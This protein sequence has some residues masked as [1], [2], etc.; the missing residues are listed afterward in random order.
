[1][2][3]VKFQ[4]LRLLNEEI[5]RLESIR[6][7]IYAGR[8]YEKQKEYEENLNCCKNVLAILC[9]DFDKLAEE[10]FL[11]DKEKALAKGYYRDG[12]DW[13]TAFGA[14]LPLLTT[15]KLDLY[16]KNVEK[17]EL[18]MMRLKKSMIRKIQKYFNYYNKGE[19]KKSNAGKIVSSQDNR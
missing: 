10:A 14:V 12:E 17:Q 3:N 6:K 9:K 5:A 15:E 4:I 8:D 7:Q 19:S 16:Y 11:S 1:M 18:H 2:L 13:E